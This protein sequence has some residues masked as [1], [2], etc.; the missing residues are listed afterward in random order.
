MPLKISSTDIL[1]NTKGL[2]ILPVDGIGPSHEGSLAGNMQ[3][4]F[5]NNGD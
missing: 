1:E 3:K 4:D 2:I 5:R